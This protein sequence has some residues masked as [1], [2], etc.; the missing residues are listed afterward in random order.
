MVCLKFSL[1][2]ATRPLPLNEGHLFVPNEA[3]DY[4]DSNHNP[5]SNIASHCDGVAFY[6]LGWTQLKDIPA[7]NAAGGENSIH[8]AADSALA[9]W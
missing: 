2:V 4:G 1:R 5:S 9:A 3:V 8:K 7:R 6:S